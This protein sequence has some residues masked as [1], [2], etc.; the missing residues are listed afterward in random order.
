MPGGG[1]PTRHPFRRRPMALADKLR[2][3]ASQE[4]F[5][6]DPVRVMARLGWWW[7]RFRIPRPAVIRLGHTPEENLGMLE[8]I[9]R[10]VAGRR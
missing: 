1:A 9:Y 10:T 2:Y 8:T 4:A 3:L 5:G 7:V 6:A